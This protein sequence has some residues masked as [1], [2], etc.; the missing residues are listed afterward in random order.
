MTRKTLPMLSFVILC[1]LISGTQLSALPQAAETGDLLKVFEYRNI[2]PTR[3]GGRIVDFAVHPEDPFVFYVAS[4]SGGLWKTEN[5][6]LTWTPIF[7]KE[8]T[9]SIGD[10]AVSASNPDIVW[11]G[12]GETQPRHSGYSY[13]GTGVFKSVDAGKTWQNMGL[14]D[15]H[16][17]GKILIHPTDP[18]IVFVAA[19]GHFWSRNQQRGV[20][21]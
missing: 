11:V 4:A 16:H 21:R 2:G 13:S 14:H 8:S 10:V 12:T 19:L 5:N 15:T 17:I 7:E 3:Q 1:C 9:F 6:G 18:G 20:F